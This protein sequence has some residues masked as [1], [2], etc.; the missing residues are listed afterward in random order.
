[1][2]AAMTRT[3]GEPALIPM[4]EHGILQACAGREAYDGGRNSAT[5]RRLGW[6]VGAIKGDG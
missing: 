4:C 3:L 2:Y 5:R 6:Q 1:M